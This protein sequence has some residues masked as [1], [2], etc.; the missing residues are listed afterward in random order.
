MWLFEKYYSAV[1]NLY[2][3]PT[4]A[5]KL[6]KWVA[7]L[8]VAIHVLQHTTRSGVSSSRSLV[9]AQSTARQ[10]LRQLKLQCNVLHSSQ[11]S[12]CA[13]LL[14]KPKYCQ[15]S[16]AMHRKDTVHHSPSRNANVQRPYMH[17]KARAQNL[18]TAVTG[19][20]PVGSQLK[21]LKAIDLHWSLRA[22]MQIR[23]AKLACARLWQLRQY[24]HLA[25][26]ED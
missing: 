1:C 10:Q 21:W 20:L 16:A 18:M 6:V 12:S 23:P 26:K 4:R 14:P 3:A 7:R 17:V 13:A 8:E 24:K 25:C 5:V 9:E 2:W 11:H 15:H 19:K 22:G